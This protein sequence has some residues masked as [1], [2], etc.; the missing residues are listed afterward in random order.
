MINLSFIIPTSLLTPGRF[1]ISCWAF[2][3]WMWH[4]LGS[5]AWN[6]W[7]SST[8]LISVILFV[9]EGSFFV[10]NFLNSG[11]TDIFRS[12]AYQGW[13][14]HVRV[15]MIRWLIF[16][17]RI[18][19]RTWLNR[20]K[21]GKAKLFSLS[22]GCCNTSIA[23]LPGSGPCAMYRGSWWQSLDASR[24]RVGWSC[25]LQSLEKLKYLVSILSCV[26]RF[27]TPSLHVHSEY[28]EGTLAK[29]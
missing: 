20:M 17:F 23:I 6:P 4:K 8:P 26:W 1:L 28:R 9:L 22:Q 25:V 5:I 15:T 29:V 7:N 11:C 27:V 18:F 12:C 2:S 19:L 14:C 21:G 10:V 24:S 16:F 13:V 3:P